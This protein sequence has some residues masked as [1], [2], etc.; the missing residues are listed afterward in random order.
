MNISARIPHPPGQLLGRL[1]NFGFIE[2]I[3]KGLVN[4]RPSNRPKVESKVDKFLTSFHQASKPILTP[5]DF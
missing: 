1:S 5:F 4:Q 3:H 2:A